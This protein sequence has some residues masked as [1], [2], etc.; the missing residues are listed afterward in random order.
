MPES[1]A[2][3]DRRKEKETGMKKGKEKERLRFLALSQ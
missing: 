1:L 3:Q 2:G